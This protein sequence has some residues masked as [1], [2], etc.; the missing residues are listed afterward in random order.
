MEKVIHGNCLPILKSYKDN[1]FDLCLTDPP[2]G[3]EASKYKRANTQRGKSLAKCK[4]YGNKNWYSQKPTKEYFDE[5]FRISK[6]QIFFGGNYFV[7]HLKDSPCW[8]V[9]DKDNSDNAYA[10][11]EL[12]YTSFNSAVR[13]IKF[14]WHGMLQ[15]NMA[16]KEKRYHPTQKPVGL[17][18]EILQRYA[19]P[20][21]TVLDCFAGSGSTGIAAKR[22]GMSFT[23]IEQYADYIEIIQQR[24][25][26][27]VGLFDKL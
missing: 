2:Y 17:L 4:D 20:T 11:C 6:N 23:L 14:K 3:I 19:K 25:K 22:L 26:N 7:E 10:D 18:V 8:I 13:K 27:E 12:V 1:E 9:W 24:L 16:A 15:E 21:D 5:M